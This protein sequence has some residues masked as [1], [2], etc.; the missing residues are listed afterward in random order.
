MR[1]SVTISVSAIYAAS[2]PKM[3]TENQML[4]RESRI[5]ATKP[6]SSSVGKILNSMKLSRKEMPRDPRSMS[7]DTPPVCR[8]RWKRNDSACKWL[9]TL[10]A[11]RRMA[12]CVTL[13][14]MA[15]RNS[16]NSVLH[17]R[18]AP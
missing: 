5:A 10:I 3:I 9:N 16:P 11:T 8:W 4:Y 15:S 18:S 6:I 7:R 1:H 13:A 14:K 12:R 17:R 2:V